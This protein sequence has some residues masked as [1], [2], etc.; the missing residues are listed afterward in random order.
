MATAADCEAS[1]GTG[2]GVFP[3]IHSTL[4]PDALLAEVARAYALGAPVACQLL[5]RGL[6]DTYLVAT[7]GGRY[8]AR[9]YRAR[10]RTPSE[11]A[12]ELELLG[13]LAARGVPVA[14]PVPARDG[15]LARTLA[16]AEGPRQLVVFSYAQGRP[17]AWGEAAHCRLA[18]RLLAAVHAA[19]DGFA[20]AH[21]RA[22]L[23]LEHLVDRPLAALRP[24][25][26]HRPEDWR[27]LEG[28]AG[29]LRARAA[30]AAA[31]GLDWGVC[32]GD[33]GG[34]NIHLG[35]DGTPTVF[36]FDLC[37]PGWR[38][39]DLAATRSVAMGDKQGGAWEAFV[40]GYAEARPLGAAD[41]AAAPLFHALCHL[42]SLGVFA[43]NVAEWGILDMSDWLLD[44]EL[45]FFRE[46]EAEHP[47]GG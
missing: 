35:E 25:L 22:P 5:K 33:F 18:G 45:A 26:A 10:W 13:H 44:R 6:N 27:Y 24:F 11:I 36:D 21:A 47:E 40:G 43:D 12:Y 29:R 15:T 2:G 46:W 30:A 8:V 41:L 16:A 1:V 31:A 19:A 20:S 4:A 23:D 3:V 17:L 28:L 7:R 9:V 34:G 37:G 32:H 39:C 14:V 38:A 42:A